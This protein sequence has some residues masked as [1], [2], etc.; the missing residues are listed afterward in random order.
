MAAMLLRLP[1]ANPAARSDLKEGN[2]ARWRGR[3]SNPVGD[4]IRSRAGS[5]PAAFRQFPLKASEKMPSRGSEFIRKRAGTF[6]LVSARPNA[7]AN[8]FAPTGD[9]FVSGNNIPIWNPLHNKHEFYL[10]ITT[11]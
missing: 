3:A 1:D 9:L 8:E 11:L 5:T 7:F 6:N 4:G 2:R 10:S